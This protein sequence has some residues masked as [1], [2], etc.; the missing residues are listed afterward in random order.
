LLL[1]SRS[2]FTEFTDANFAAIVFFA[3]FFAVA[4]NQVYLTDASVAP[5]EEGIVIIRF[6][7]ALD[8]IFLKL[9]QWVIMATPF[10]VFSLIAQAVGEQ[11]DIGEAFSNVGFLIVA[12][13]VGIFPGFGSSH[14]FVLLHYETQP[15]RI[16]QA[17]CSCSNHGKE[18][19]LYSR[20]MI[21]KA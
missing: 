15:V 3:V 9:I 16:P 1:H 2:I 18:G 6:F 20:R 11:D 8:K 19:L 14:W 17:Y 12:F 13:A 7:K 21:S 10:A 4:I 5:K